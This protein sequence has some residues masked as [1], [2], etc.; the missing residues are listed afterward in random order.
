MTKSEE[1]QKLLT[2]NREILLN[3]ESTNGICFD[4]IV[5]ED[6]FEQQ[7]VKLLVLLK[8]TNGNDSEGK[9]QT[10][11]PDWDYRNW[12]KAQQAEGKPMPGELRN[13][14]YS[15]TFRKLC[16]W[17]SEFFEIVATGDCDLNQYFFADGSV[18]ISK[19]RASLKKVALVNLKK[20]WGTEKTDAGKLYD[21]A[22]K[23]AIVPILKLQIEMIAPDFVLCCSSEVFEIVKKIYEIENKDCITKQ[24]E[25]IPNKLIRFMMVGKTVFIDFIHPAWYEKKDFELAEYAKEVFTWILSL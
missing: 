9:H 10:V 7:P 23:P 12:L 1:I 13:T 8:E 4:G 6:C 25:T 22:T 20:S 16:L 18:D 17:L 11:L 3:G 21:Y 2:E 5:D 15:S 19:V 14:F 24:S